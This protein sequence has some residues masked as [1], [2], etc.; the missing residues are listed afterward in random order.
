MSRGARQ[1]IPLSQP[2]RAPSSPSKSD[3]HPVGPLRLCGIVKTKNGFAVAEVELT[4]E[5]W[6]AIMAKKIGPSQTFKQFIAMQ[7]KTAVMR[8]GQLA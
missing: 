6:G 1:P 7:H 8:L 4:V 3:S 5:E 2:V